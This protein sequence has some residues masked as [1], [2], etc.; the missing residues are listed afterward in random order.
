MRER[1]LKK[2]QRVIEEIVSSEGKY[3]QC[4]DTVVEVHKSLSLSLS[5]SICVLLIP[6]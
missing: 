3:V 1:N 4:L 2:Q 6:F 5:L